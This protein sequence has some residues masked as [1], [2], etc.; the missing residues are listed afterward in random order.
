MNIPAC[1][2]GHVGIAAS[3]SWGPLRARLGLKETAGHPQM[4]P[5]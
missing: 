3:G 1:A 5:M 4:S 2:G